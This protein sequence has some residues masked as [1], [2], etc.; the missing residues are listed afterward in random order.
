[1]K[2]ILLV[3][4]LCAINLSFPQDDKHTIFQIDSLNSN[5]LRFYDNNEIVNA[6]SS[7]DQSKKLSESINDIYG[8][9][10]AN[11]IQGQIYSSMEEYDAAENRFIRSL[12]NSLKIE[13]NYLIARSYL[14]LGK[15]YKKKK[16]LKLL[17]TYFDHALKYVLDGNVKDHNNY[18]KQQDIL[19]EIQINLSQIYL[20]NNSMEKALIHLLRAEESLND[21]VVDSDA[22]AYLKYTQG[23]YFIKK[24]LFNNASK[25][26]NEALVLLEKN[27][28]VKRQHYN[29]LLPNIYKELAFSFEKQGL[30]KQAYNALLKY[31]DYMHQYRAETQ[32][33]RKS[34]AKSEFLI[35]D[36]KKDAQIANTERIHQVEITNKVKNLNIIIT[37]ALFL[38]LV[39]LIT[40]YRSY[41]SKRRLTNIL[42]DRN[43]ELEIARNEAV[44]SS[45]LK[46]KFISNVT[47]ELRTPLYGV[48]GVTSL[49]LEKSDLSKSETKLLNSLKYSGD[50]L[51]NLINDILQ[52]SKIE[53]HKI[54][55]KDTSVNLKTLVKN[56]VDSF[57]F[58]LKETNNK[59]NVLI[60]EG[61]PRYIKCDNVRLSQIL[62]NLIGNSIKFTESGYIDLRVRMI[63]KN[64]K[65]VGI[66]FEIEDNGCGIPKHK[67]DTVFD[68]F[69]QLDENNNI[70]YQGTGLGLSITKN[71][72]ELFKSKIELESEV[73]VGSKFSFNITFRI[74]HVVKNK[75]ESKNEIEEEDKLLNKKYKILVVEDNKINQVVTQNLLKK[76]NY[77]S[78]VVSNGLEALNAAKNNKFDLILMD[79]NMPIMN[80]KEATNHIR[81]FD[82][83]IPIIALTASD[84]D[85][86]KNDCN[87][88]GFNDII[89]KPFDTYEFYQIIETNIQFSKL[90]LSKSIKT[91]LAV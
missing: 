1:M 29:L 67:F 52:V 69:S 7:I 18:D 16:P 9:A 19:F 78:L 35:E 37:I 21:Y 40:V 81:E 26:F 39:S 71:L 73:G 43:E 80:G 90:K 22:Y 8:C 31:N 15:L 23:L 24:E 6:L 61:L 59:I 65:E 50:Y 14:N 47:H 66:R 75:L 20:D 27:N 86:V 70:N 32:S 55:L 2:T 3:C 64:K 34:I 28:Q 60:D 57:D 49:L 68:N 38:F 54:E 76:A 17:Q 33:E 53:S 91:R 58:R 42:R 77:E 45:E 63:N 87:G 44:K 4:F 74:D 13:D 48:V 72:V 84:V 12:K 30:N 46:S 79:I 85:S 56:I 25:K 36:Y 62:I 10:L 41:I 88:I 82:V 5:A 11:F 51:L 89:Y 83:N